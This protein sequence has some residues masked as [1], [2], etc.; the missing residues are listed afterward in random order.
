[1]SKGWGVYYIVFLAGAV[2]LC[3]PAILAAF[4]WLLSPPDS[5]RKYLAALTYRRK[6]RI[7]GG[8]NRRINTRFF[9]AVNVASIL[10]VLALMLVPCA[11]AF[12]EITES[13]SW[14]QMAAAVT[15]IVSVSCFLA[16]SLFYSVRK[17]DLSWLKS[18]REDRK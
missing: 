6:E 11:A 5:K 3:F 10:L 7:I 14:R 18:F 1:M 12:K 9:L 8:D 2:G 15:V 13:G 17:G 16:L 4:A